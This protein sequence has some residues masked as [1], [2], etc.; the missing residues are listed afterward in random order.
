MK[1]SNTATGRLGATCTN[2][3]SQDLLNV[4]ILNNPAP[5]ITTPNQSILCGTG[6]LT[7][8]ATATTNTTSYRWLLPPGFSA[9]NL[10]TTNPQIIV[11]YT[12]S[13]S[14]GIRV[15]SR[16]DNCNRDSDLS[17]EITITRPVPGNHSI[18]KN[19][20]NYEICSGESWTITCNSSYGT[21]YGYDWFVSYS[22]SG[23]GVLLNG[24]STSSSSPLFTSNNSVTLTTS[25]GFGTFFVNVRLNGWPRLS[26][27]LC[28]L[29]GKSRNI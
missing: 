19:T 22:G 2:N 28:E 27:R 5:T 23:S 29:A 25:G 12:P 7:I 26:L 6:S 20:S 15:Y 4:T 14:G 16:N 11:N 17:N 10:T 18:S 24:V 1:W 21:N 8:N 3:N 13:A 9:P